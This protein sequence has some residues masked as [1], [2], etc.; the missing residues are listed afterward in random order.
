MELILELKEVC[1]NYGVGETVICA[2]KNISLEI[3]KGE[4]TAI[5]GTS[6]SGKTTLLNL[7]GGLDQPTSGSIKLNGKSLELL[8]SRELAD[9]R[10]KNL[11]FIFQTFNLLPVL[12]GLE[13]V[14]Y[15][16]LRLGLKSEEIKRRAKEAIC[17]VGLSA[18]MNHRPNQMSGG[19]RQRV[20]IAR[21]MIHQPKII[22][23]D[24]PTANLDKKTA[25]DII[26][27]MCTL[28]KES[29]VTF[30]FS[31][32]DPMIMDSASRIIKVSDGQLISSGLDG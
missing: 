28:N 15:P 5:A 16:L 14:E 18:V 24:E 20:A 25:A 8:T 26:G 30:I 4:F 22:L 31:T 23:A 13:N 9:L 2:V 12:S 7:I 3:T 1:K 6:G 19:Q 29:G 10:R 32:H 11:G 17:R 21:A 27:L